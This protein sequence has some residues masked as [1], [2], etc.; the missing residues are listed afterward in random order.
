MISA[1]LFILSAPSGAGKTTL[2]RKLLSDPDFAGGN[3]HFSVSHTTRP[4]RR[5]EVDGVAYHFVPRTTF[6]SMI[7]EEGFLEWAEVHGNYYGT[8][9][10]EVLPVLDGG[11]DVLLDIDVQGAEIL[12]RRFPDAASIFILPPS[13]AVLKRRLIARGLDDDDTVARRLG[14]SLSEI[15]HFQR[16]RYAIVND[17]ADRAGAVLASIILARRHRSRRMRREYE[18]IVASF[19]EPD[20]AAST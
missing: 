4:P 12:M 16:Y 10:R 5:G 2:I 13:F 7:E 20:R 18:H 11:R 15:Q 17:D 14:V 9:T 1:D 6:E 8:S 3:L 19:E